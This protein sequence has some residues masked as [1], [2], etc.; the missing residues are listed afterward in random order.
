VLQ[1]ALTNVVRHAGATTVGVELC[2]EG[3]EIVLRVDDNG[4]GVSTPDTRKPTA[5]GVR[6]MEE[7]LRALG[8]SLMLTTG[9]GG[10]ARLVARLPAP[11]HVD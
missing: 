3:K 2:A 8:G 4:R 1:E 10:G 5:F 6:G 11:R 7:R 9:A